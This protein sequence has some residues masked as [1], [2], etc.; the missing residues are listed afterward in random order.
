MKLS[1][2]KMNGLGCAQ[3]PLEDRQFLADGEAHSK[4]NLLAL[5]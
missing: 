2:G 4:K 5:R 3:A 1:V